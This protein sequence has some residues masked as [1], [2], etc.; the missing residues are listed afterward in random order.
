MTPE[1]QGIADT[2][3]QLLEV[4]PVPAAGTKSRP[5]HPFA[6]AVLGEDRMR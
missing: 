6:I 4:Q 5:P 1:A 2:V 3:G